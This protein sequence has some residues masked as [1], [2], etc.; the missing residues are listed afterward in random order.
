MCTDAWHELK[1]ISFYGICFYF[2]SEVVVFSPLRNMFTYFFSSCIWNE[3]KRPDPH[4]WPDGHSNIDDIQSYSLYDENWVL[5]SCIGFFFVE[6]IYM[7]M[8]KRD[9]KKKTV[10]T[11]QTPYARARVCVRVNC[12][13]F[14]FRHWKD[15]MYLCVR[16]CATY[17]SFYL[18]CV[19]LYGHSDGTGLCSSKKEKKKEDLAYWISLQVDYCWC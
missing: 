18:T 7:H 15:G 19:C 5:N 4:W 2:W 10:D 6:V 13:C 8:K 9:E 3:K 1:I 17:L 14:C 16:N 12:C 11:M